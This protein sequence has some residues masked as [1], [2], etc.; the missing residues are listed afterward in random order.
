MAAN[1]SGGVLDGVG[2]GV[3]GSVSFRKSSGVQLN[4]KLDILSDSRFN[5]DAGEADI[6]DDVPAP[7]ACASPRISA[8]CSPRCSGSHVYKL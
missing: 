7:V 3:G 2:R 6:G 8:R 5:L 4:V 1:S